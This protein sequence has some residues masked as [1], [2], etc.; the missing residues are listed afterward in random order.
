[1]T[2]IR[3]ECPHCQQHMQ[4]EAGY[5]G[6]Q[7]TC[8]ACH[9]SFVVPGI[10]PPRMP[11]SA[12]SGS[13]LAAP[14]VAVPAPPR[15]LPLPASPSKPAA[16]ARRSVGASE[17]PWYKTPYPYLGAVALVL[18]GLYF[19]AKQNAEMMPVFIGC[20]ALYSL[21]VHIMVVVAAFRESVGTGFLTLCIPI[22][23]LYFV[24]AVS[25]SNVLKTLYPFAF[26]IN[27]ALRFIT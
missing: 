13:R 21:T 10:P 8:P 1:M 3:F 17:G 11:V 15:V 18:G 24:F 14:A 23:G 26:V 22:Y 20:A 16:R 9:G 7:I 25:E 6:L 5:S 2:D 4:A 27:L 12:P 19:L